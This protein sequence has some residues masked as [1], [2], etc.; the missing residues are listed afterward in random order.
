MIASELILLQWNKIPAKISIHP[1]LRYRN[2]NGFASYLNAGVA[3]IRMK[4][5]KTK[6]VPVLLAGGSGTRLWPVSR[7]SYPKQFVSLIGETTLFQKAAL[8]TISSDTLSFE[9]HLTLTSEEFR[10]IIG[11]Q[12]GDLGVDAGTILIE[13][14]AKNTAPAILAASLFASQKDRESIL[15]VVPSDHI[16]S[17]NDTFHDAIRKGMDCVNDGKIVTFGIKPHYPETGF[18][19]LKLSE[20]VKQ[21]PQAQI[22]SQFVEKPDYDT[23]RTMVSAG[24]Y[25]WNS[26]MLLFKASD[27]IS[28]FERLAP[29]FIKLTKSA[30]D[31]AS[32]DFDFLRLD[33]EYWN[34]LESISIDYA[35]LE[36]LNNLVAVPFQSQ[37]SDLGSW[38]AVWSEFEKD[39]NGVA[40]S[41]SAHAI[42]CANSL[43][44]SCDDKQQI[45]GLGLDDIVAV[46]MPDAVLVANKNRTQDVKNVVEYLKLNNVT[47]AEQYPKLFR[48]WGWVETLIAADGFKVTRICIEPGASLSLQRHFK[49]SEHWVVLE[50]KVDVKID[51]EHHDIMQGQ[52]IGVPVGIIHKIKN[53]TDTN[54]VLIEIQVG[55]Y[56][57]SDDIIRYEP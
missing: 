44:L 33:A 48:P 8:R 32:Q 41:A 17:D 24:N 28:A 23:A 43:L 12:L 30:I 47:Q 27:L 9:P 22:I 10:F 31:R 35:L 1:G 51:G 40:R 3:R 20:P 37:W 15:L 29:S 2:S 4:Q 18:G 42:D 46:A 25:L 53:A 26:G 55:S 7:K 38:Q 56:L 13:P 21:N 49:R 16:I 45:V 57:A 39:D 34:Q 6:I 52:S 14:K 50:G 36:K 5:D 19:Y 54:V 11:H